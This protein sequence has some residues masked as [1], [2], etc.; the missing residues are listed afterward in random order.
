MKKSL[1]LLAAVIVVPATISGCSPSDV[2]DATAQAGLTIGVSPVADLAPLFL[3][4]KE[5]FF[6]EQGIRLTINTLAASGGAVLNAVDKGTFDLGFADTVSLMVAE[7]QGLDVQVISGAAATTGDAGVDYAA[8]VAHPDSAVDSLD[9]LRFLN[10]GVDVKGSTNDVVAKSAV[11]ASGIDPASIMWQEVP[12]IDAVDAMSEHRLD[13]AFLVE[14]FVTHAR[15]G[16]FRVISHPYAEF[17][18]D[19]TVSGYVASKSLATKDPELVK[20][21]LSALDDSYAFADAEK[22]SARANIGTYVTSD[23]PVESRLTLPLFAR[24]FDRDATEKLADAA[25]GY[26]FLTSAPDLESLLP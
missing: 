3:G 13:A 7:E 5:G 15:L 16:G 22:F 24:E 18:P 2:A 10:V 8:I 26:R 21:F 11:A 23:T 19:L 6:E 14:P 20:R 9:D 1:A 25:V 12:F 17:D 4:V